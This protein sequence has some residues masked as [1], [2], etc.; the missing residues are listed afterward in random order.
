[1]RT[2]LY[3]GRDKILNGVTTMEEVLRVCQ[4]DDL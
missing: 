2:L 3:D 4:Q 1:M